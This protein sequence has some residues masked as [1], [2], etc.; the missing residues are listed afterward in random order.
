MHSWHILG[1]AIRPDLFLFSGLR[2][3]FEKSLDMEEE[4]KDQ[5]LLIPLK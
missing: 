4:M 3:C 5:K 2:N 1:F